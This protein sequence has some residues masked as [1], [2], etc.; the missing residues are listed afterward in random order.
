MT[1]KL[2]ASALS[3]SDANNETKEWPFTF[4]KNWDWFSIWA[5]YKL[6]PSGQTVQKVFR[7]SGSQQLW[8]SNFTH[9]LID[10]TRYIQVIFISN[11][12]GGLRMKELVW[13]FFGTICLQEILRSL[14]ALCYMMAHNQES[15]P[16]LSSLLPRALWLL[17]LPKLSAI[18]LAILPSWNVWL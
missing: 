14:D 18:V 7:F 8:S 1:A 4:H 15:K 11:V 16:A 3:T 10:L 2:F 17:S 9:R 6:L 12:N 13:K 5:Q